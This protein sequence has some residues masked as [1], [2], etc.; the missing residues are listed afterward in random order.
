MSGERSEAAAAKSH[1]AL[2]A[3]ARPILRSEAQGGILPR[4]FTD[5]ETGD[6]L[7]ELVAWSN[8]SMPAVQ[9]EIDRAERPSS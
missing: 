5:Q 1:L 8:T 4:V 3:G 2:C 7:S 9:R 6:S